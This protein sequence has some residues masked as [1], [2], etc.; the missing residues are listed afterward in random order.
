MT[1]DCSLR[2][3]IGS[4]AYFYNY[5]NSGCN[6]LQVTVNYSGK[7]ATVLGGYTYGKSMDDAGATKR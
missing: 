1:M 7:R 4:C 5:G 6:S 2:N 3:A